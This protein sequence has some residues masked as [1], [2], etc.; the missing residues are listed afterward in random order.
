VSY[1]ETKATPRCMRAETP[2]AFERHLV[3]ASMRPKTISTY[4]RIVGLFESAFSR[5][6]LA[7]ATSAD[8]ETFLARPRQTGMPPATATRNLELIALRRLF[9]SRHGADPTAGLQLKRPERRDPAVPTSEQLRAIFEATATHERPARSLAIV[10]LLFQAG[11]R[12][13]ELALD[14]DQIDLAS[15][16]VVGAFGK[17]GVRCDVPLGPEAVAL[18]A[19]WIAQHPTGKGPLFPSRDRAGSGS[20]LSVRSV[21][22]LLVCLRKRAGLTKQITPHSLRHA[23]ATQAIIRGVDLPSVAALLR[24]RRIET[25]MGYVALASE[26]RREA[27]TRI[28]AAIPRS[29]LP[30]ARN[31][32]EN[33]PESG[34]HDAVDAEHRFD[35]AA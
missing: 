5:C 33:P 20:H 13:H 18:L 12:V 19:D 28:G 8:V 25:T 30:A 7:D 1:S 24:H 16:L 26:A 23:A 29:V 27:A 22:R 31:P 32:S 3:A 6:M 15:G 4:V 14:V 35:D 34:V 21:E 9:R 17:G 11:L 10:A 2:G